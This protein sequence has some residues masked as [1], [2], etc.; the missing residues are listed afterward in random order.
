MALVLELKVGESIFVGTYRI[1][2]INKSKCGIRLAFHDVPK[3]V[4]IRR[5][6]AKVKVPRNDQH[7]GPLE[8]DGGPPGVPEL[9]PTE[10]V[11]PDLAR[12]GITVK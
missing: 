2:G 9:A 10:R 7:E 11:A 1:E 3:N 12:L 4:P 8:A 6:N 5:S